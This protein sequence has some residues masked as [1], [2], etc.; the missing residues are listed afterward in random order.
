VAGLLRNEWEGEQQPEKDF[1]ELG[2]VLDGMP[3]IGTGGLGSRVW[4]GPAITVIGIDV[5]S[6]DGAVNA[7]SP[8]ARAVLNVRVHP[9][10]EAAEAQDAVISHPRAQRPFGIALDVRP[11]AT[12]MSVGRHPLAGIAAGFG[13]VSAA[14]GVNILIVPTDAVITDIT[15]E[16]A[17][18]VDPD[19]RIDLVSNLFFGAGCTLFLTVV[20]A[21]VTTRI[22]EPRLGA[23]DP[24]HEQPDRDDL[25]R[26]P[27]RGDRLRPRGGDDQG[28]RRRA[29]DDHQ[30]MG[31]PGRAHLPLP[32]D[33][34]VHR[35]L[36]LQQHGPGRGGVARRHPRGGRPR[37]SLAAAGGR[38]GHDR[39][40]LP[41]PGED[42]EVG[43]SSRR[44]S[45]R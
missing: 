4:S 28:L 40:Q 20:V 2:T 42:R 25:G 33:R 45:C 38:R 16:A 43:R 37:G 12:G 10:Q 26:L 22:I 41:H 31:E 19:T 13:A 7:V 17:A 36:R 5:P 14:F 1:R 11:G 30:V 3:L 35:V 21:L 34:P 18:L 29:R 15:N 44:S 9:E 39:G 24:V 23:W 6:V 27:R 32:A 8:Y